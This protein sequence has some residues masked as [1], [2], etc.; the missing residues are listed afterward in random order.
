MEKN[1]SFA[2]DG[3]QVD[4]ELLYRALVQELCGP[5]DFMTN[6]VMVMRTLLEKPEEVK[7]DRLLSLTDA[8]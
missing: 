2:E 6:T 1:E 8:L 5:F 7:R 3:N 4:K